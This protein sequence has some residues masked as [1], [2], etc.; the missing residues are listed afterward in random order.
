NGYDAL[1]RTLAQGWQQEIAS[2]AGQI[3]HAN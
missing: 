1:V 3:A 2:M